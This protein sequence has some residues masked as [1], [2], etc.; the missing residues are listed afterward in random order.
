MANNFPE[1][2]SGLCSVRLCTS[3]A[4]G[5]DWL[6]PAATG[7]DA[8]LSTWLRVRNFYLAPTQPQGSLDP[9]SQRHRP[10][11]QQTHPQHQE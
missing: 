5:R 4:S 8:N 2:D 7:E 6:A 9:S 10:N 3:G 1:P 11:T